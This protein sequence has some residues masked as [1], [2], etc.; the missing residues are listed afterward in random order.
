MVVK[1]ILNK[2][3][4]DV[5]TIHEKETLHDVIN[6]LVENKFGSLVVMNDKGKMVGIITERDILIQ[7]YRHFDHLKSMLVK[8]AMT[9]N[10]IIGLE[11]DSVET[12]MKFMSEKKIRHLP[13]MRDNSLIGIISMTDIM[14]NMINESETE[15]RY[16]HEY[17]TQ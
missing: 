13:I 10:P 3:G 5:I 11:T 1:D 17:I 15:I 9:R 12:I 4:R 7:S 16:L 8:D 6:V 2:K 14:R